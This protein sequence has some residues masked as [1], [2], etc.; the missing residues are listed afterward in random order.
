MN[1]YSNSIYQR[2]PDES[3]I[4][5]ILNEGFKAFYCLEEVFM[6]QNKP[7]GYIGIPMVCFC[8]IPLAYVAR[9][10]YGKCGIAMS[11]KWGREHHLE[12]VLYYPN[13]VKCQSTKMVQ[14][15][16]TIFTTDRKRSDDYRILGYSKPITKP[17]KIKGRNSDNYVE[18]EWRKVY[19]NPAPLKWLTEIEYN[20][21]RGPKGSPKQSVGHPLKFK[22]D[23]IDFIL[24][25]KK[26]ASKLRQYIM[27]LPSLCNSPK[28]LSDDER[29]TLLSKILIYE[30]LIHNL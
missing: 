4:E 26:N 8:D 12:P 23:D 22:V 15:A 7:S 14:T 9:N 28:L 18:R 21:Y 10:N 27:S 5:S 29:Y 30:D 24:V 19:A 16:Y 3:I 1:I 17:T 25:D 2:M 11:R 20:V 6:G 13:D